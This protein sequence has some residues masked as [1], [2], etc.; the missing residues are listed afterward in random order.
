MSECCENVELFDLRAVKTPEWVTGFVDTA[1][2]RVPVVPADWSRRDRLGRLKCRLFNS[3]RMN[4][5]VEPGIY[6]LGSPDGQSPVLVTAN[7]KLSFDLLRRELEG[8]DAWI[9]VLDTRGIN[10]WCAAG[11]GTFGTEELIRRIG[12]THLAEIVE[13]RRIILPQLGAP[14]VQAHR[15]KQETD[16]LISYG[17]VYARDLPAYLD[18]GCKATAEMRRAQFGFKD[19]L[20]LVPMEIV[21]ASKGFLIFLAAVFVVFGLQPEGILFRSA[22]YSGVPVAVLGLAALLA[23]TVLTPLLLPWVPFRSFALK[24]FLLGELAA[25]LL[26]FLAGSEAV[27]SIYLIAFSLVFFPAASSYLA[28]QF[29]G[30]T[31]FTSISGVKKEL[32]IAL[33][34]YIAAAAASLVLLVFYKLQELGVL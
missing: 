26:V 17:P 29:T 33:P 31:P 9:V 21:P 6:A 25:A 22:A 34:R 27:R 2:G 12:S 10:V 20:E 19:R 16:F 3:V 28:L 14:G 8:F 13:H 30:S 32:K 1:S 5:T 4:Y 7:Y 18:S 15:V 11:K 23:G 24:G